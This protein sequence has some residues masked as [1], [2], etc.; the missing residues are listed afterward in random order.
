MVRT[1]SATDPLDEIL[2]LGGPALRRRMARAEAELVALAGEGG[3]GLA[4]E[5]AETIAAGGKRLRPLLVFVAGDG[6]GRD[7]VDEPLIRAAVAVEL[8]HSATLVHD[9]VLDAAPV[10]RGRPTVFAR[11]GRR[12]ATAT[13]D[14]LFARA[15]SHLVRNGDGRQL[16]ALSAASS[17]L[18]Q[19]E[20]IQRED[21][22][23]AG[24]SVARYMRRC[25]LKTA[26]LFEAA[27]ELGALA[28]DANGEIADALKGFGLQIGLAF[29]ILDDVLDVTGVSTRTGKQRGADLLD[30][31]VTLPLI[32]AREVDPQLR[33]L[34][35]H[36]IDTAQRAE[37]LCDRIAATDAPERARR[38]A[39]DIVA[40]A[41][42]ALPAPM[43]ADQRRALELVAK[44]VVERY[45]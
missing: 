21:A 16:R 26:R 31:T 11:S 7:A 32:L 28:T 36:T 2:A 44:A 20:L 29:Q 3:D 45:S 10:R 8:I 9:D 35:L 23:N 18:V 22:W 12:Q 30:G 13:G 25:E 17:A 4:L 27:C 42:D 15:F 37:A 43:R 5:A 33:S 38:Q 34:D 14:L 19:G 40:S 6:H 1:D 41:K 39:L 24:I